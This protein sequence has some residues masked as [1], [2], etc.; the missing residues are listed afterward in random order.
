MKKLYFQ[1][2]YED[3]YFI[4]D[5][6]RNRNDYTLRDIV[7]KYSISINELKMQ[8]YCNSINWILVTPFSLRVR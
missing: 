6:Y 8:K 5:D 4:A 7:K 2:T 1:K 3:N